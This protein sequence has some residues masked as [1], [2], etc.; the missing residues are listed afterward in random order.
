MV[1][2]RKGRRPISVS[3]FI[4]REFRSQAGPTNGESKSFVRKDSTFTWMSPGSWIIPLK[5]NMLSSFHLFLRGLKHQL[6]REKQTLLKTIHYL[7]NIY[8]ELFS[9]IID[10]TLNAKTLTLTTMRLTLLKYIGCI[11]KALLVRRRAHTVCVADEHLEVNCWISFWQQTTFIWH[12][13]T[14]YFEEQ[15]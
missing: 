4:W 5:K 11:T 12:G 1:S 10:A 8:R 13:K 7:L 15:F 6:H 3:F 2:I 14:S 9:Q